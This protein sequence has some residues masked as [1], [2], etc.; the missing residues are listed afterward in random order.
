MVAEEQAQIC[1]T[2]P[3]VGQSEIREV[4]K[5]HTL[6]HMFEDGFGVLPVIAKVE[7]EAAQ[8]MAGTEKVCEVVLPMHRVC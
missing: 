2:A 6:C 1:A 4:R 7:L 3:N 8:V 5:G